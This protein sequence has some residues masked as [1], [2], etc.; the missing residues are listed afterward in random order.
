M[1]NWARPCCRRPV[2]ADA[3]GRRSSSG[4]TRTR[5]PRHVGSRHPLG[6]SA[7]RQLAKQARRRR[8]GL[9]SHDVLAPGPIAEEA[10]LFGRQALRRERV[11]CDS[12][13]SLHENQRANPLFAATNRVCYQIL[14]ALHVIPAPEGKKIKEFVP[15]LNAFFPQS[16]GLPHSAPDSTLLMAFHPRI[17]AVR[18]ALGHGAPCGPPPCVGELFGPVP[19]RVNPHYRPR[20][21]DSYCKCLSRNML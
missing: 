15:D 16:D 9:H 11:L 19:A 5:R 10:L 14:N 2:K 8:G 21:A 17:F 18:A 13:L 20:V 7:F 1:T 6:H 3:Y 4:S 12:I